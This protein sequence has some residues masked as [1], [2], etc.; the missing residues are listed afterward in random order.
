MIRTPG[1]LIGYSGFQ[2]RLFPSEPPPDP[3]VN[4]PV[5]LQNSL[6]SLQRNLIKTASE[7]QQSHNSAPAVRTLCV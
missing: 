1:T 4:S 2:D 3:V 5:Q 7:F 6:T